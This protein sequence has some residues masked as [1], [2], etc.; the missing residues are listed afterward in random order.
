MN[1]EL[2]Q[3]I[4]NN[5]FSDEYIMKVLKAYKEPVEDDST[6]EQEEDQEEE[7]EEEADEEPATPP[8][9]GKEVDLEKM[10]QA[11]VAKA[12]KGVPRQKPKP[13]KKSLKP[14]SSVSGFGILP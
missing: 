11:A 1:K 6:E 14:T 12:L 7:V 10:I 9:K 3:L 2:K 4:K 5:K 13:S 8:K